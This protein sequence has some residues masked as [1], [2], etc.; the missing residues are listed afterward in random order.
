[1]ASVC[2]YVC[3]VGILAMTQQGAAC[4]HFSLSLRRTDLLAW[5]IYILITYVVAFVVLIIIIIII[6]FFIIIIIT[7]II[8]LSSL[9]S[10][11]TIMARVITDCR[12]YIVPVELKKYKLYIQF[13]QV[14]THVDDRKSFV[15]RRMYSKPFHCI[16]D[17]GRLTVS[18]WRMVREHAALRCFARVTYIAYKRGRAS[19]H[20]LQ[21]I[22]VVLLLTNSAWKAQLKIT[23]WSKSSKHRTGKWR[24][25]FN[26]VENE[27]PHKKRQTR[28][29]LPG[30]PWRGTGPG[31]LLTQVQSVLCTAGPCTDGPLFGK[32][33][34]YDTW[35]PS[36]RTENI[37]SGPLWKFF[38]LH[39]QNLKS[40]PGQDRGTSSLKHGSGR[41]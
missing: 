1:M 17:V 8:I 19:R 4:V 31:A 39:L 24:S 14:T 5:R 16:L 30:A 9:S 15:G 29:H 26:K 11:I 34:N 38:L 20:S 37:E 25:R 12:Q 13:R 21:Y 3:P 18:L 41:H 10:S 35:F 2:L 28:L 27:W 7:R 6:I 36:V 32:I 33:A 40:A 22:C 23:R